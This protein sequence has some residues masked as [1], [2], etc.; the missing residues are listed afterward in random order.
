M[1]RDSLE[2]EKDSANRLKN[3]VF[4]LRDL[5]KKDKEILEVSLHFNV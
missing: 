5:R 2:R 4:Q 1:L 3:E